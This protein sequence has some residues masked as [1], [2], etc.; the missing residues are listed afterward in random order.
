MKQDIQKTSKTQMLIVF[1]FIAY[2]VLSVFLLN[3]TLSKKPFDLFGL[4]KH[5]QAK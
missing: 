3:D 1:G 4:E 2:I 5:E